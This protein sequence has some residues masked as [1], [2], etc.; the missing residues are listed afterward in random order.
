[1]DIFLTVHFALSLLNSIRQGIVN[2]LISQNI[3]IKICV[4]ALLY[5]YRTGCG[6][7]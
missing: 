1:M 4:H 2:F 3:N 6:V 5:H 7:L